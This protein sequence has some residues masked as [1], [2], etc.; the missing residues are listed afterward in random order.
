MK[1]DMDRDGRKPELR[2]NVNCNGRHRAEGFSICA[3]H[4]PVTKG[5]GDQLVPLSRIRKMKIIRLT[6]PDKLFEFDP[7]QTVTHQVPDDP[8]DR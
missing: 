6:D 5:M 1:L 2:R 3:L 7:V 4:K 8:I